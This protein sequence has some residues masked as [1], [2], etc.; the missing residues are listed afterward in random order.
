MKYFSGRNCKGNQNTSFMLNNFLNKHVFY[1]I[2]WKNIPR[3]EQE[4]DDN[5]AHA[6]CTLDTHSEYVIRICF[7]T[8]TTVARNLLYVT[9]F[10]NVFM[11]LLIFI[12]EYNKFVFE[13]TT[14][15]LSHCNYI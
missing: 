1:E 2:T 7:S 5:V 12:Q 10:V 3:N 8:A 9:F 4:T 13:Y 14:C 6:Q 11:F 15:L